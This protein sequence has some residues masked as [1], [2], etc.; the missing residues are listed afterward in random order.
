M[1][2]AESADDGKRKGC[3]L[4]SFPKARKYLALI[5]RSLEN[6]PFKIYPI[7][8]APKHG[9]LSPPSDSQRFALT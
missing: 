6:L 1:W 3:F 2:E 9:R 7:G 8:C 5:A 4:L